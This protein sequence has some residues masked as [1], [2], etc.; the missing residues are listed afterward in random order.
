M[1]V[2]IRWLP[3]VLYLNSSVI[4]RAIYRILSSSIENQPDLNRCPD[5]NQCRDQ[6]VKQHDRGV[7]GDEQ[8]QLTGIFVLIQFRHTHDENGVQ[9][10]QQ[11]VGHGITQR[12]VRTFLMHGTEPCTQGRKACIPCQLFFHVCEITFVS[13]KNCRSQNSPDFCGIVVTIL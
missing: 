8:H 7:V 5:K 10:H 3:L 11:P 9:H 6:H 12:I 13:K 4:L 2:M 1:S